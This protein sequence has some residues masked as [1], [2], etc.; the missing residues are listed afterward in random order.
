MTG[1]SSTY[2]KT[3]ITCREVAG[4]IA[5]VTGAGHG[6]GREIALQLAALGCRVACVDKDEKMNAS[7]V[8]AIKEEGGQAW[9]FV[10]VCTYHVKTM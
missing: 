9:G 7:T 8:S 4:E 6:V 10:C 2:I 5:L 1:S 3:R